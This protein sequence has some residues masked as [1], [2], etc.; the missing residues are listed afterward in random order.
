MRISFGGERILAVVAH[1]DDAE[2][3]CAGTLA[4]ARADGAAI[5]ILVLCQGDKGQPDPPLRD[6]AVLRRREMRQAAGVIEAALFEGGFADGELFDTLQARRA[7]VEHFRR[8]RP[9]LVLTHPPDDY[10]PDHRAASQLADAASW[11]SASKGHVTADDPLERPPALWW[12]DTIDMAGFS[13]DL[14]VDVSDFVA[15]KQRMLRCHA[16]QLARG[17]EGDFMPLEPL[18]LRQAAAR[19]AQADVQA[20]EAFCTRTRWKRRRAW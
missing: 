7:L 6:L 5:G 17:E 19:G 18:M 9:T 12:I 14:Y 1:P 8:F 11:F 10:H 4:R 15:A 20:A 13:P 2:L 3:F 16:S